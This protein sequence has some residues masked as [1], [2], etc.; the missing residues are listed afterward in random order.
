[1]KK[2][3]NKEGLKDLKEKVTESETYKKVKDKAC[4]LKEKVSD[5][6]KLKKVELEIMKLFDDI[7]KKK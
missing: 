2:V 5:S 7:I 3:V 6:V 4:D 1:M